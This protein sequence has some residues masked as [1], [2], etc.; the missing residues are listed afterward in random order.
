M[1]KETYESYFNCLMLPGIF[2]NNVQFFNQRPIYK[3]KSY[4]AISF[5]DEEYKLTIVAKNIYPSQYIQ[6]K[7][8]VSTGAKTM[9]IYIP[10]PLIF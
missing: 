1:F 10:V 8:K 4:F 5:V 7:N 6:A 2:D 9:Y 3:G